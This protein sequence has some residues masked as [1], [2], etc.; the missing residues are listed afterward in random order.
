MF[1]VRD[2]NR[3]REL[4]ELLPR[5]HDL[6]VLTAFGSPQAQALDA[7]PTIRHPVLGD[8]RLVGSPVRLDGAAAPPRRPPPLLGE[9]TAEVLAEIAG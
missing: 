6:Y 5:L 3:G 7:S 1:G 4:R 2:A 8:I 9:H